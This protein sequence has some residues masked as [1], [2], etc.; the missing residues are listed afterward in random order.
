MGGGG[1]FAV[2]DGGLGAVF[3]AVGVVGVW[4]WAEV[5]WSFFWVV[6]VWRSVLW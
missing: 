2:R 6:F 5:G 4:G 1:E 3:V